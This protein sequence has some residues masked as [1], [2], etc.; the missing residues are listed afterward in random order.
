MSV[1][2]VDP[3]P[4]YCAAPRAGAPVGRCVPYAGAH[5]G[6]G[7][8]KPKL[9]FGTPSM[10]STPRSA[11]PG[12]AHRDCVAGHSPAAAR[13]FAPG[14]A[15]E[16]AAARLARSLA[17]QYRARART[18]AA[19]AGLPACLAARPS[20]LPRRAASS[21]RYRCLQPLSR[22]YV[23]SQALH[24]ELAAAAGE[25]WRGDELDRQLSSI[26]AK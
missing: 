10:F 5:A 13:P 1:R 18:R 16:G 7:A 24:E 22:A 4:P 14:L 11:P 17:V 20:R 8:L 15:A 9:G 23:P 25:A 6:G 2:L 3:S 12:T 26:Q 19:R 21:A